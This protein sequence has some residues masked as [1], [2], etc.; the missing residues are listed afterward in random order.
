MCLQMGQV[1]GRGVVDAHNDIAEFHACLLSQT[2]FADLSSG[3]QR[4]SARRRITNAPKFI[5][6]P[7]S[8]LLVTHIIC[9]CTLIT[10]KGNSKSD[11]PVRRKPHGSSLNLEN[12]KSTTIISRVRGHRTNCK[13][14]HCEKNSTRT[15]CRTIK[16]Q[17]TARRWR[18]KK[19]SNLSSEQKR[20]IESSSLSIDQ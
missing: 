9:I 8:N 6:D 17:V 11:P 10:V 15:V 13:I 12:F 14:Y 3:R 5:S 18:M 19:C 2:V 4:E 1:A 20:R 16:G 7:N